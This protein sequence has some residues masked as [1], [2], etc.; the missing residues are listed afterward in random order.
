MAL[1]R[2]RQSWALA[3]SCL[4]VSSLALTSL[5]LTPAQAHFQ[6]LI[7]STDIVPDEGDH[8]VSL[9]LL[10]THP[11]EGGP[12]M[13]MG[14]PEQ[15]FVSL[16]GKKTDLRPALKPQLV[17][18]KKAFSA[19]YKFDA[20]GDAI[21]YLQPA[22]YWDAAEKHYLVHH[23]KVIVDFGAGEDWDGLIGAPVEIQPLSRPYGLWTGNLFRAIALKDGKPLPFA[24]V[25]VEWIN[26]AG[27][28]IP[29]DPYSTQVIKADQNGT[30]AYA[31]PRAGWWGFNV[32]TDG[33]IKAPDGQTA[34][35]EIGG[36][37]WVKTIDLK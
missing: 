10:F 29:A 18:G 12:T 22:P 23:T 32:V 7:P 19:D 37:L 11:V 17:A 33:Q 16:N 24:R 5:T 13:D 2:T 35:A 1:F 15:F 34:K 25:E 4:I 27:I 30:F 31:M 9:S 6:E 20:P 36:T 21:F 3:L 26:D 8:K 14:Q 28:K